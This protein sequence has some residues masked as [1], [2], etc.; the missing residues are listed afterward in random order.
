MSGITK[1][2]V[3]LVFL[4][5]AHA[6][7]ATRA[8]DRWIDS[9]S[10]ITGT[11]DD[12][13]N[14]DLLGIGVQNQWE[15][16]WF[17]DGAWYV[18]GYWDM[19]LSRIEVDSADNDDLLALGITPVLRV[20]RDASLSNGVTPFAEAGIGAHLLTDT[21]LGDRNFATA[22]QFASTVGLGLG[23]GTRGQYELSY[24]FRYLS[25][26]DIKTPNDDLN[27]H[28]VRLGYAF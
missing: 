11:D 22:F 20:Q 28:M 3:A 13:L 14:S 10:L 2:I 12:S 17:T 23:F 1:I 27:L 24:R 7:T 21:R 26:A 9:V 25:N 16:K 5:P 19:E 15:R 6:S 4:L 18:G 8:G